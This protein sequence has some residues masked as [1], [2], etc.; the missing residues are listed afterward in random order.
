MSKVQDF[1]KGWWV[2]ATEWD[3]QK[4]YP[5]TGTWEFVKTK[6][7]KVIK[8]CQLYGRD[9]WWDTNY[10]PIKNVTRWFKNDTWFASEEDK[11]G[12]V[13]EYR[14]HKAKVL[15]EGLSFRGYKHDHNP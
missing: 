1:T 15:S 3:E 6:G 5:Q 4:V 8:A 10:E 13:E 12:K 2:P 11:A 7:G 14:A 9:G